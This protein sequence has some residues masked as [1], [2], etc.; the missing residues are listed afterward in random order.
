M[1]WPLR[2]RTVLQTLGMMKMSK[3][4]MLKEWMDKIC[5]SPS[6]GMYETETPTWC[7]I[8]ITEFWRQKTTKLSCQSTQSSSQSLSWVKIH[9]VQAKICGLAK[10]PYK[11]T[12]TESAMYFWDCES[13]ILHQSHIHPP[14][15]SR[16]SRLEIVWMVRAWIFKDN[17]S[18]LEFP[19]FAFLSVLNDSCQVLWTHPKWVVSSFIE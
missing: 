5:Q 19:P 4:S 6:S 8:L 10:A 14:I 15:P 18:T 11:P 3:Q 9:P 13:Q 1:T 16:T 7:R 17:N 12:N 2:F